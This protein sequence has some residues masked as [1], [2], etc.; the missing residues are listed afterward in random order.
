MDKDIWLN[1]KKR[2]NDYGGQPSKAMLQS[3]FEEY[4]NQEDDTSSQNVVTSPSFQPRTQ[5]LASG[6]KDWQRKELSGL[7]DRLQA[8]T[9]ALEKETAAKAAFSWQPDTS[10]IESI[11]GRMREFEEKLKPWSEQANKYNHLA[12]TINGLKMGVPYEQ[13]P[14]DIRNDLGRYG[15]SGTNWWHVKDWVNHVAGDI[16]EFRNKWESEG[17]PIEQEYMSLQQAYGE[18]VSSL[19]REQ[20][21]AEAERARRVQQAEEELGKGK[22][23]LLQKAQEEEKNL[24]A[25]AQARL[26]GVKGQISKEMSIEDLRKQ[27][28]LTKYRR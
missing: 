2:I 20:A 28:R 3:W 15:F 23:S 1:I 6:I 13:V 17:K 14:D 16:E 19:A 9:A 22:L 18:S 21:E 26:S 11:G 4:R 12:D 7:K 27:Q 8:Q 25:Q 5:S 24:T 10:R